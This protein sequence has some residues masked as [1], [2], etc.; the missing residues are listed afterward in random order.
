MGRGDV[1][2]WGRMKCR[3]AL[4]VFVFDPRSGDCE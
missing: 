4:P 2:L 3:N 1:E